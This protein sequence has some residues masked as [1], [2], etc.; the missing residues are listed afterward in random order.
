MWVN[1]RTGFYSVVQ[2]PPCKKDELLIRAHS[3]VDIDELQQL[4]RV[5][6]K[7]DGI[8]LETPQ[9]DYAYRMIV[10]KK[11]LATFMAVAVNDFVTESFKHTKSWEA[12]YSWQRRLASET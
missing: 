10:P 8:V 6:Y 5:N 7:Y 11:T 4:L 2:K 1:L 9:G 12:T 3:K